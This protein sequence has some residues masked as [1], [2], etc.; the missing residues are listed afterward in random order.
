MSYPSDVQTERRYLGMLLLRYDGVIARVK[1]S[2]FFDPGNERLYRKIEPMLPTHD[3]E[4]L[5]RACLRVSSAHEIGELIYEAGRIERA[6]RYFER[7]NK[8]AKMRALILQAEERARLL[9][10]RWASAVALG[11]LRDI[12][13]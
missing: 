11:K 8:V 2:V 1:P 7:L 3:V 12:G 6:P 10:K 5:L 4:G 9:R 13:Q